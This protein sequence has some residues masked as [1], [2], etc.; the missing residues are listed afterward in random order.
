MKGGLFISVLFLAL[1]AFAYDV[2]GV[3]LGAREIDVKKAFP[4]VH[5]KA[6]EWKSDAADRRCDDARISFGGVE[7]KLTVYLKSGVIQAF[8]LRIQDI[9]GFSESGRARFSDAFLSVMA[10]RISMLGG[11][12]VSLLQ[13]QKVGL[14]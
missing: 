7:C 9:D 12:L 14:V 8:D 11:R 5:C 3:G 10:D 2:N 6:L 4:S 1:P 13:E